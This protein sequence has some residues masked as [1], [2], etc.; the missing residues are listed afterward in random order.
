[1]PALL[2]LE[3][4]PEPEPG[5]EFLLQLRVT[6]GSQKKVTSSVT[7]MSLIDKEAEDIPPEIW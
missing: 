6:E 1:L 7:M 5:P 2:R 4:F 3:I